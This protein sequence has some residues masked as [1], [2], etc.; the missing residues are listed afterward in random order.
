M[1]ENIAVK[2]VLFKTDLSALGS[3][4]RAQCLRSQGLF[5]F[6]HALAWRQSSCWPPTQEPT[7]LSALHPS[8]RCLWFR[9][10]RSWETG[11]IGKGNFQSGSPHPHRITTCSALPWMEDHKEACY[12]IQPRILHCM[13]S[14]LLGKLLHLSKPHM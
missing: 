5:G 4:T 7:F 11:S 2:M 10:W 8:Q 14:G 6:P 13:K 9:P 3:G 12:S 1:E